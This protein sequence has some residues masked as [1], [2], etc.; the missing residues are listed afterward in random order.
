M[1]SPSS[2]ETLSAN[3]FNSL[4]DTTTAGTMTSISLTSLESNSTITPPFQHSED[5]VGKGKQQSYQHFDHHSPPPPHRHHDHDHDHHVHL[6]P[7]CSISRSPPHQS[8]LDQRPQKEEDQQKVQDQ[9]IE[10]GQDPEQQ[11]QSQLQQ[12][13]LHKQHQ[14][15]TS[16]PPPPSSSSSSSAAASA[17]AAQAHP[18]PSNNG[19]TALNEFITRSRSSTLYTPSDNER[20]EQIRIAI[21]TRCLNMEDRF[22]VQAARYWGRLQ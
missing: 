7:S 5:V 8:S 18:N 13:Q 22:Q 10:P 12:Q 11:E 17:A 14:R 21:L 9:S 1:S 2:D 3:T 4:V 20:D 6:S 16:P 19:K 15:P